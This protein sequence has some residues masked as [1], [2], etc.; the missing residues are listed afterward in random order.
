M[1]WRR[2]RTRRPIS[3]VSGTE[4][5]ESVYEKRQTEGKGTGSG[6]GTAQVPV[7]LPGGN[8][9]RHALRFEPVPVSASASPSRT[10]SESVGRRRSVWLGMGFLALA[11]TMAG[12]LMYAV[13]ASRTADPTVATVADGG[14]RVREFAL[15]DSRGVLHTTAE[16]SG[17]KAVV[18]FFLGMHSPDSDGYAPEIERLRRLYGPRGVVFYGLLPEPDVTAGAAAQYAAEHGLSVPVLLDLAQVV[19]GEAGVRVTPEAVVLAAD[20]QVIYR[21]RIDDRYLPDGRIRG[22]PRSREL[23]SALE[24]AIADEMP[25]VTRGPSHG[26]PLPSPRSP[27]AAVAEQ[28]TFSKHVAPILW[29]SCAGCHRP[30]EVGPFSLLTYRDA[31]KR[32]DFIKQVTISRRMP[33]WKPHPGFGVFLDDLRLT[34]RELELL[35]EWADTGAEEGNPADLPPPPEFPS[36]WALG[37]PD[38]VVKMPEPFPVVAGGGDIHRAFV[39]PLHLDRDRPV[40]AIEL[41]PGNRKVVHHSGIFAD[42]RG[43]LHLRDRAEPGPGFRASLG[44]VDIRR[45]RLIEWTPGTRPRPWPEGVAK[46]LK[47][48]TDLVLFIHYHP[49]G[50]L[51]LDQSAIGLY[52]GDVPPVRFMKDIPLT[53]T[54]IDIPPGAR[55]HE[56]T[57]EA[58]LPTDAHAF[59][60]IPHGHLLM[61]EL[62][63]VAVLPDGRVQPMLWIEDWDLNWQGQ[64]QFLKPVKLPEGTRLR[65]SAYY[66]NSAGNLRNPNSPP[67]RVRYGPD[68]AD[69][70]LACHVQVIADRPEGHKILR[71]RWPNALD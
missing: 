2:R 25:V 13:R 22:V 52:F 5:A 34:D 33:P 67:R 28:I 26:S 66:D 47:K 1:T 50:K 48:G 63:L 69:E 27:S 40:V 11:L 62:R 60:L 49:T 38:L 20:G 39:L 14:R 6:A 15:R 31:A 53:T 41:R 68:S 32:A 57:L 71:K 9:D 46:V 37:E 30:G 16:W 36:G 29:R 55:R 21:G 18:L 12:G 17:R 51:E 24:A 64:Y 54:R 65:L 23:A 61:R 8:G 4:G 10:P 3:R 35:A 45:P 70:M 43:T 7:P 58:T 44:G 56:I 59:G 19:A 42:G